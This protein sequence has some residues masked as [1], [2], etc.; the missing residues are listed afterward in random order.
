MPLCAAVHAS[1]QATRAPVERRALL[2]YLSR[3]KLCT[4]SSI[5]DAAA[6]EPGR[7]GMSPLL[8]CFV[9]LLRFDAEQPRLLARS[10]VLALLA[11]CRVSACASAR[12][13]TLIKLFASLWTVPLACSFQVEKPSGVLTSGRV[14]GCPPLDDTGFG[15][16]PASIRLWVEGGGG[17][18]DEPRRWKRPR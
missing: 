15:V 17:A 18:G 9:N 3:S 13:E 6:V 14:P 8:L 1:H 7:L 10:S 16:Y 5:V 12:V 4:A 11:A 2:E